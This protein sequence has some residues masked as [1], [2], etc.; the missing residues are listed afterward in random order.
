LRLKFPDEVLE[1]VKNIDSNIEN[2][3]EKRKDLR[4]LFTITI[5]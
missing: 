2:D 4:N 3:I 5:D 1:E